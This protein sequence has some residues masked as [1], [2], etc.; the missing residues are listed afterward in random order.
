MSELKYALLYG[1]TESEKTEIINYL[2]HKPLT[3]ADILKRLEMIE[4]ILG[5]LNDTITSLTEIIENR[6][7]HNFTSQNG[8]LL[9]EEIQG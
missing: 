5:N 9:S 4:A 8:K 7:R 6:T 3:E 1:L 2:E